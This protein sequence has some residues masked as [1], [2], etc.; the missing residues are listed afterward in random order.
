MKNKKI[1]RVIMIFLCLIVLV[2]TVFFCIEQ[3][4]KKEEWAKQGILAIDYR[5]QNDALPRVAGRPVNEEYYVGYD[6]IDE[7]QLYVCL[8]W[9]SGKK[10][11]AVCDPAPDLYIMTKRDGNQLTVGLWNF[12]EDYVRQPKVRLGEEWSSVIS[13][14]GNAVL[15]GDTVIL[16]RLNAFE[17]KCFTLVK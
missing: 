10:L 15:E 2:G 6:A 3:R 11:D 17:C 13:H 7:L 8:P 14:W 12:C 5:R 1:L 16:D 4:R 9:L